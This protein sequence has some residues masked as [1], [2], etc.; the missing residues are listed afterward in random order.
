MRTKLKV[1]YICH[2]FGAD[3][4]RN[5]DHVRSTC[6]RLAFEGFLPLAPQL[7]LPQFLDDAADRDRAMTFCLR[8]IAL[9]DEVHVYG[10][11]SEG[12]RLEIGE[13]RRLGIPV[14]KAT[15]P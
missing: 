7:W 5:T 3:A 14:V 15:T 9:A 11:I 4:A 8:L 2:A 13:A 12:M 1:A 6:R 10:E